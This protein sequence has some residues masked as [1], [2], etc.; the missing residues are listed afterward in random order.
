ME[1]PCPFSGR[2]SGETCL[3]VVEREVR[4]VVF[5][6]SVD[7]LGSWRA[8][9]WET[10]VHTHAAKRFATP[11][12]SGKMRLAPHFKSG[13]GGGGMHRVCKTMRHPRSGRRFVL[14]MRSTPIVAA[15]SKKEKLSPRLR[16]MKTGEWNRTGALA[17]QKTKAIR[18]PLSECS[19][20]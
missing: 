17:C 14:I 8:S 6:L 2:E 3:R 9:V 12:A 10:A 15:P 4:M 13:N 19:P 1:W 7:V 18:T 16:T 11:F 5:L 20:R